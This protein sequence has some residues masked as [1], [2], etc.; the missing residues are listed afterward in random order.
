MREG[1]LEFDFSAARQA[2]KLDDKG[3]KLPEGMKF[4]DFVVEEEQKLILLE[5]KDPS[6][7]PKGSD[8]KAEVAIEKQR[9]EFVK[10]L[11]KDHWIAQ[12]LVP[13]ARDS[14]T[15]LHLMA[16]D[17]KPTVYVL[18]IGSDKL[19]F[20]PALLAAFKD[21]LLARIRH[22]ADQAWVREYVSDC[23]IVTEATWPSVF[24]DYPLLRL[25]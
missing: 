6:C 10:D 8:A 7:K 2:E 16:R 20:E 23:L 24:P 11:H 14:Y 21:R 3:K 18:F 25:T 9:A 1:E 13:K 12:E 15:F 19:M 17:S 5:I 4:V 22:E